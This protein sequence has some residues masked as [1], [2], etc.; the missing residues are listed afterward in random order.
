VANDDS[1]RK[2]LTLAGSVDRLYKAIL[3]DLRANEFGP[4]RSLFVV[5]GDKIRSLASEV[6]TSEVMG[7]VE[8]LLDESIAA[9]GY[10]IHKGEHHPVDLSKIDFEALKKKFARSRKHIEAEKLRGAIASKLGKMVRLNRTRTDYLEKFQR[11]IDEYNAG[12]YNIDEFFR[13]L[14]TFAQSLNEEEKR[15]ISEQLTEEELAL[16]DLLTK[17]DMKLSRKEEQAVK[18]AARDLLNTL[19]HEKLVLDWRKRQQSRAAVRLTIEKVLEDE[20]PPAY[21]AELYQQKCEAVYQH[22]YDSY[23]GENRSLYAVAT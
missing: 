22:V 6:D 2:Y 20:L 23:Y 10:V 3:P 13:R 16:F 14:T 5:I 9:E 1:K 7:D 8:G 21:S 11:M 18:K 17:P 4:I 15:A 12:S 19:K